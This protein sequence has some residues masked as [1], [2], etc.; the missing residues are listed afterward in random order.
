MPTFSAHALKRMA[1][2]GLSREEVLLMLRKGPLLHIVTDR[3]AD[4]GTLVT[5]VRSGRKTWAV[6][7]NVDAMR[8]VTVR[9]AKKKEIRAYDEAPDEKR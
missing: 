4:E 9:P 3:E 5:I 1:E 7:M 8:I 6:V 2:R